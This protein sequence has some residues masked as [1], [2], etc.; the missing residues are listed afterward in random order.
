MRMCVC[1][2]V[3]PCVNLLSLPI[4]LCQFLCQFSHLYIFISVNLPISPSMCTK[5]LSFY[6]FSLLL[7]ACLFYQLNNLLASCHPNSASF[8]SSYHPP[9][10]SSNFSPGN[11]IPCL[12][13][14]LLNCQLILA[15]F[16]YH[17]YSLVSSH[18]L[19]PVSPLHYH[20]LLQAILGN[21]KPKSY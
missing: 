17:H 19:S 18:S 8:S 7:S 14:F 12:P 16:S 1:V 11:L 4:F 15:L 9:C 21:R 20:W 13:F 10:F 2:Y 3:S 5:H 6:L